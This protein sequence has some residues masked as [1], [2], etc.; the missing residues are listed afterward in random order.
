[1]A[2]V[3]FSIVIPTYNRAH[4]VGRAI[5][6]CLLQTCQDFEI[7]VVDDAKSTDDIRAALAPYDDP[8]IRL[9]TGCV[10]LAATA[11]N[12]GIQLARG[13]Y[14]ALLDSDDEFLPR[15]LEVNLQH[16]QAAPS[17]QVFYSQ[18]YVDRGVGKLWVK[19]SRGILPDEDIWHYLFKVKG[20]IH[21]STVALDA[22]L[23]KSTP[24]REDLKF[25]DDTQFAVDLWLKGARFTMIETPLAMYEDTAASA[26]TRLSQ[27][28][29]FVDGGAEEHRIY[30]SWVESQ[31]QYMDE[32]TYRA[33]YAFFF[34]RLIAKKA[35]LAALRSIIAAYQAGA[36]SG[37]KSLGQIVQT[38][39]PDTY[40]WLADSMVRLRGMAPPPDVLALRQAALPR[41]NDRAA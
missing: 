1:M 2:P 24:Y 25:G 18:T 37:R 9:E 38:F 7:I 20:W 36:L 40:R 5:R 34:S 39:A 21:T 26:P 41:P 19:P 4:T 17:S 14:V 22:Q 15:K 27:T 28:P 12:R 6:S 23:A 30:M 33:A 3:L 35:P 29:V 11:R 10:G 13:K 8:R 16:L 32:A 31:R